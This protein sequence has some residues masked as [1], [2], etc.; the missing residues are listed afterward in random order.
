MKILCVAYRDWALSIYDKL[1]KESNC[2]L[3]IVRNRKEYSKVV[4]DKFQPDLILFYGW[5]WKV[6]TSIIKKYKCIMLHPSPLPKYRGGSPIQNQIIN[7]EKVS[8]VTLF[9]MDG[10]MDSGPILAQNILSL[11]GS[12]KTIFEDIVK[13]GLRLTLDII[14]NGMDLKIQN[15]EDATVFKRRTPEDSEITIEEIKNKPADYL[16][17]KVRMLDYPYP[18]AFIRTSDGLKLLIKKVEISNNN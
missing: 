10:N 13:V 9:L 2:E 3:F 6:E 14:N 1:N 17:N 11:E 12:L 4:I 8:A 5:S 7:G 18:N 15:E 16:Y